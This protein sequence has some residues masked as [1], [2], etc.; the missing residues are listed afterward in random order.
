MEAK[1]R[2][3]KHKDKWGNSKQLLKPPLESGGNSSHFIHEK[4]F[5]YCLIHAVHF[6]LIDNHIAIEQLPLLSNRG[7]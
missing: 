3:N 7:I 2:V 5:Y 1:I 4:N 6:G